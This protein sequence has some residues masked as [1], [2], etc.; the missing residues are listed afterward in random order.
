[1]SGNVLQSDI[2]AGCA[3]PHYLLTEGQSNDVGDSRV[4]P[5]NTP[6]YVAPAGSDGSVHVYPCGTADYPPQGFHV[7]STSDTSITPAPPRVEPP[8]NPDQGNWQVGANGAAPPPAPP[9]PAPGADDPTYDAHFG[10]QTCFQQAYL[11]GRAPHMPTDDELGTPHVVPGSITGAPT[12]SVGGVTGGTTHGTPTGNAGSVAGAI[13]NG[14]A[15]GVV[16]ANG[17]NGPTA[18]VWIDNSV[19]QGDTAIIHTGASDGSQPNPPLA[20]DNITRGLAA[21]RAADRA[22][23]TE[24]LN[25]ALD[26]RRALQHDAEDD[27]DTLA[28]HYANLSAGNLAGAMDTARTRLDQIAQALDT[29]GLPGAASVESGRFRD[30]ALNARDRADAAERLLGDQMQQQAFNAQSLMSLFGASAGKGP[31][32]E[33][34]RALAEL[35]G[36]SGDAATAGTNDGLVSRLLMLNGLTAR[37]RDAALAQLKLVENRQLTLQNGQVL[38]VNLVHNGYLFGGGK[39]AMDCSSFVSSILPAE[40]RKGAFT[41]ADFRAM[42]VYQRSGRLPMPPQYDSKRKTLVQDTAK[43]FIPIDIYR[44]DALAAGDL[45]VFRLPWMASGHILIVRE[46]N[47]KT[48]EVKV[49][50]ASQTAGTIREWSLNLSVNPMWLPDRKPRKGFTALRLKPVD[51]E[52]CTYKDGTGHHRAPASEEG[53]RRGPHNRAEGTA[54]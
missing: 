13:S 53:T 24:L 12:A 35:I 4:L 1:M 18:P 48:L 5:Y 42:W 21:V 2:Q 51:T 49:V 36:T 10:D 54:L 46:F 11:R 14:A 50:D 28:E 15:G 47:P 43:A 33:T 7:D 38:T 6:V 26:R 17:G 29:V 41:T 39:S 44:G 37:E 20:V 3:S 23:G 22:R 27:Q 19:R 45:L 52:V 31:N 30:F 16:S 32:G 34:E 25:A 40:V 9:P 8:P